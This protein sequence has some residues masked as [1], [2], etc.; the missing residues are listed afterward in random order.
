M[1]IRK[2]LLA[3][4]LLGLAACGGSSGDGNDDELPPVEVT[5]LSCEA[6]ERPPSEAGYIT[7]TPFPDL[8]RIRS[9]TMITQHSAHPGKWFVLEQRGTIVMFDETDPATLTTWLDFSPEVKDLAAETN[10]RNLGLAFHPDYP[11]VPEVFVYYTGIETGLFASVLKRVTL[12]DINNPVAPLIETVFTL[13]QETQFHKGGDVQFGPDG[14]LYLALGDGGQALRSQDT[15]NLYG[16]MLR[17]DVDGTGAGYN[18]PGDNPFAAN[19]ACTNGLYTGADCAEIY[20]WGLRNPYRWDFDANDRLWLGDVGNNDIEEIDIIERGKN[21][22]WRCYEGSSEFHPEECTP[23]TELELPVYDYSHSNGDNS[24]TGGYVYT[25]ETEEL[26]GSYVFADYVSGR[27]WSLSEDGVG[28]WLEELL[29]DTPYYIADLAVGLDG[30]LYIADRGNGQIRKLVKGDGEGVN[31][32]P[33]YLAGTSCVDLDDPTVVSPDMVPYEVNTPLWSD[34]AVKTRYL[35]IPAATTIDVDE[36]D[37]WQFPI[38]SVLMKNFEL[39][40]RL[41]E[42]RLFMRHPDGDWGG[43]TWEWNNAQTRATRVIGGK[44]KDIDGTEWLYPSEAQCMACHNGSVGFALS[45]ETAQL[46]RNVLVGTDIVDQLD[47]LNTAGMFTNPLPDSATLPKLADYLDGSDALEDRARAYLHTNCS[48]CHRPGGGAPT[49]IDL[50]HTTSLPA[51][52]TCNVA[53]SSSDMG[54]TN[55]LLIAP[56]E[57]ARSVLLNRMDRRDSG[58]M[59]PLGTSEVDDAAVDL[60]DAWITSM[61]GCGP[62][63]IGDQ[64]VVEGD[65]LT[66]NLSA[67]DS[68]SGDPLSFNVTPAI[69]YG[70]FTDNGDGSATWVLTPA[71][72]DAGV[73]T[74]TI[75]VTDTG[76][77]LSKEDT[78]ALTVIDPAINSVSGIVRDSVT[79]LPIEGALVTLQ[80]TTTQAST[81]VDGSFS[82][83]IDSGSY[84]VIVGASKGYY[85][86]SVTVNL[87]A[88]DAEIL[89]KPVAIGTNASY[90]F[91]EPTTCASCHPDQKSEWDNSAMAKAG[92]NTWVH[93]IFDGSGT[94]GGLGGFVYTRDSVFAGSNPDS[95]CAA[96]HQPE[97]WIAAGYSGRMESPNDA[98]Y[99][100]TATTHGISCETCHKI[101]N[102]DTDKIDFPGIF[103]EAV[104]FNQSENGNQVQYGLLPDVDYNWSGEMEPSYQPQLAAEVC[105][106]CHQDANDINEDHTFAGVIS[107]PTYT[108]WAESPYGDPDSGLYQSCIECHMPPSGNTDICTY[109]SL[110]RDPDTVRTHAIEGTTATYL[111][112]AVELS[113]QTEVVGNEL[114]VD[115][116]IDNSLTGHHVPTGV[117]VRNMILVVEAWQDGQ[118]PLVN[119]LSHTG[120][121]TIHELGGVG[122]PAQ[123]Y[124]AGQPGKFYAKVNHDENLQGPTFFTD[125][126]G[127]QFDNRIPALGV[128]ATNYTFS[129][130]DGSGT[131][132][133][134]A[135]LIYRRAF[136]FL[137]DAKNWTQ[138]GHGNALEDVAGPHYGHLMEMATEEVSF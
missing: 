48:H 84:L 86:A 45:P 72:G 91:I 70:A 55:P 97:S 130:P 18:I 120:A 2:L 136:R 127:I 59:P 75:T 119:P 33:T 36:N 79:L 68:Y 71:P 16:A 37:D 58:G 90:S 93:D 29:I 22:G 10:G 32:I 4:A 39:N 137:V 66:V 6:P 47:L 15:T 53:P 82:L 3:P 101:A 121:Q 35:N 43:Y 62:V 100:S 89:L 31:T 123:G 20:A 63:V 106:A 125:A 51:T 135:R 74:V 13:P 104:T 24:V 108:E 95:E 116:S 60:I 14:Y 25:G 94:P 40:G 96:C 102:V 65:T 80:A 9:L 69:P 105:G 46:N 38:G 85:N 129:V 131:I 54:I 77:G 128:D 7:E 113:M 114:Q 122:D 42:T 34:G 138:D 110:P 21:Y 44:T 57:P 12:D 76:T 103:P 83:D 23:E 134:R 132:H 27:M 92:T 81:A 56:G 17:L 64:T 126:T 67:P 49:D 117:T 30:E 11:A 88:T 111:D 124:Y 1:I 78:F 118:D 28:N 41:V 115:V 112:N 107:E 19:A 50:R 52:N 109:I 5:M 98:G 87:P 8:A 26:Q 73:M 99:P 61:D 133:V